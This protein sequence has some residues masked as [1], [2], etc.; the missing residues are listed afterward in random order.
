VSITVIEAENSND[1]DRGF[2]EIPMGVLGRPEEVAETVLWMI[3]TGYVTNKVVAVDGELRG[4]FATRN[5]DVSEKLT[6]WQVECLCSDNMYL[7]L[8]LD[9]GQDVLL[10]R[11]YSFIQAVNMLS[12]SSLLLVASIKAVWRSNMP[13][14][15]DVA[16][17]L[18]SISCNRFVARVSV[19]VLPCS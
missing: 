13:S 4:P 16:R 3:K 10:S 8:A 19:I 9:K 15:V 1:A 14:M 6:A 12:L 11:G 18:S 17:L 5:I 2:A 7:G